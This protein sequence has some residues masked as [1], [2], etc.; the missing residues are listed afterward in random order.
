M[1]T[2]PKERHELRQCL[3]TMGVP[4]TW[5]LGKKERDLMFR[6]LEDA[7][8]LEHLEAELRQWADDIEH[9]WSPEGRAG[10]VDMGTRDFWLEGEARAVVKRLRGLLEVSDENDT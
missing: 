1:K 9:A 5:H 6:L 10:C 7:D 4:Q 8:R 3:Y 2:T